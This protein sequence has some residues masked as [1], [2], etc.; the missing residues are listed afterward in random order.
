M[1]GHAAIVVGGQFGSESKGKVVA[2]LA[3]ELGLAIRGGAPNAGHTVVTE[4]ET[5]KLQQIPAAFLNPHR[6][7]VIGAGALIDPKI[8]RREIERTETSGR[9]SIDPQAGIIEPHHGAEEA[10]IVAAIGST[11][12][13]CGAALIDRIRRRGFR[14]AKDALM[15]LPLE[16]VPLLTNNALDDGKHVLLEGGQGFGLS[17]YHGYYPF[18]TSRDTTAAA[19]LSEIGI[20]PLAA[21]DII[22]VIRTFPIRVAGNSG[23]LPHET[24]WES[25]S[26]HAGHPVEERTT[27]TGKIRRVAAFDLGIVQDAIRVNRPTQIALQFLNYLFPKDENASSWDALGAEARTHV[28]NLEQV[29]DVPITLIGTGA[30]PKAMVDRRPD[31]LRPKFFSRLEMPPSSPRLDSS[32]KRSEFLSISL[33]PGNVSATLPVMKKSATRSKTSLGMER[34]M[35]PNAS[36]PPSSRKTRISVS[37]HSTARPGSAPVH[38]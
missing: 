36:E 12:K 7:L 23:P 31:V 10:D 34:S 18:V 1:R 26:A 32:S 29:L 17:L 15:D 6:H 30:G 5:H 9:L 37:M 4:T 25:L 35:S 14:L 16:N 33:R 22:L 19:V 2:F 21:K 38:S 28:L 11:G 3:Q 27:V 13:G 24:T 20:S 8:L